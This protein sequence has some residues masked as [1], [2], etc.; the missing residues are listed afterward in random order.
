M[1]DEDGSNGI[2]AS[3]V[4]LMPQLSPV[5]PNK[6]LLSNTKSQQTLTRVNKIIKVEED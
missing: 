4:V 3:N 2:E 1:I 5:L 6:K